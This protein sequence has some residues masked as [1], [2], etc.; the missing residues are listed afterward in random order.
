[1]RQHQCN[2]I[3]HMQ[4]FDEFFVAATGKLPYAYQ[5]RLALR[6]EWP[7]ALE[8]PTGAGKTAAVVLGWLWR[9]RFAPAAIRECT[10]R[11]LVLC[12]P[13]RTL[14]TQAAAAIASWFEALRLPDAPS[15]H[16][17][18]GGSVDDDW[19][20]HPD[21]DAV[22]V[23][24]Q[25]MLLSRAL[26]RGFSMSR[27][28]WPMAFGLLHSD[29]QWVFD[30]V[31]L[32]GVGA[33]T[34]AQL[35]AFRRRLG[36][37]GAH[38]SLWMS[39]TLESERLSTVDRGAELDTMQLVPAERTELR[40][41]L[42]AQKPLSQLAVDGQ[43]E[44]A[45]AKAVIELHSAGTRTLLIVNRV[46]RAQSIY[47]ELVAAAPPGTPVALLHS[48]FRPGDRR[49]IELDVLRA[50]W[51]GILVSTQTIEAGVDISCRTLVTDVAVWPS[52]V[53]R[54]GR[55]NRRAES[56]AARVRWIDLPDT[57]RGAAPYDVED[58]AW[59]RTALHTLDDVSP[60]Q[61]AKIGAPRAGVTLPVIRRREMLDLFDTTPDLAGADID[62]S[63]YIRDGD[64]TDLS[65][66]WRTLEDM[67]PPSSDAPAPTR[68]ERC[69]VGV[70]DAKELLSEWRKSGIGVWRWDHRLEQW[71]GVDRVVPG[72]VWVVPMSAGGYSVDTGLVVGSRDVVPVVPVHGEAPEGEGG[73]PRSWASRACTLSQHSD[74]VCDAMGP[75]LS[76]A[77]WIGADESAAL[78]TAARWHDAGK[79]HPVF[80]NTM[81]GGT[82]DPQRILAKSERNGRHSRPGFRHEVASALLVLDA[83][84]AFPPTTHF[85]TAYLVAAHHGRARLIVRARP[86]ETPPPHRQRYALGIWD[87]DI[88]PSVDLGGGVRTLETTLCLDRCAFG[89]TGNGASWTARAAALLDELGPFRLSAL[90]ALLRAADWRG[91]AAGDLRQ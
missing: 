82:P 7:D 12:M 48:R 79:G 55:C 68:D 30:E 18:M 86:G 33:S 84:D 2:S 32:M 87:G 58:L 34:S 41:L 29:V 91:S 57:A 80:Q 43:N 23:G 31:Q 50:D 61:L 56:G 51:S 8:V 64:E 36:A 69:A 44:R 22:L 27:Y 40:H 66:V 19:M 90:E 10:G 76:A 72:Q 16:V 47:R 17:I 70:S 53:Q 25:D 65:V 3:Q 5:R 74:D 9:R 81:H 62:V 4:T 24:T 15:V 14:T 35:D 28:S 67:T 11:R 39:A 1:M 6:S 83:P 89:G 73:D 60:E 88:L 37:Y 77:P 75:L 46:K 59:S 42:Q 20:A 26:N 13:M 78:A 54:F 63:P 21:R 85:L 49:A 52:M 45:I 71:D 38:H